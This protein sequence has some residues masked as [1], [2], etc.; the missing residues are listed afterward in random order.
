MFQ[1]FSSNVKLQSY[2]Q[3]ILLS[4]TNE[5]RLPPSLVSM[6]KSEKRI[7]LLVNKHRLNVE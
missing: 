4:G 6:T 3:F 1:M 5:K 7:Y 2:K